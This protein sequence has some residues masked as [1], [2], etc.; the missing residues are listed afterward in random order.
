MRDGLRT[1]TLLLACALA[2]CGG[3]EDA[4]GGD[5][6]DTGPAAPPEAKSEVR[7]RHERLGVETLVVYDAG[8]QWATGRL[9]TRALDGGGLILSPSPEV[10]VV[11]F[12]SI[13]KAMEARAA[14]RGVE[15]GWAYFLTGE[16]AGVDLSKDVLDGAEGFEPFREI[17]EAL[18]DTELADA[19][20]VD[21]EEAPED[22]KRGLVFLPDE[23]L[24]LK[25]PIQ[26]R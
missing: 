6:P 8:R 9:L 11:V 21:L 20:G 19:L 25:W 10:T 12:R 17:G 24:R 13:G 16:A 2:A 26:T 23:D 3:S 14:E 7:A 4:E 5:G 18:K 15:A 1:W 22:V